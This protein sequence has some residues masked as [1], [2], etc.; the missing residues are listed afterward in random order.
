[1]VKPLFT[2]R[3]AAEK[4]CELDGRPDAD[5]SG[6]YLQVKGLYD[7][8]LLAIM[9]ERAARGASQIDL[10]E[11]CKA[12]LLIALV[13]LGIESADLERHTERLEYGKALQKLLK[14]TA[15]G[16]RWVIRVSRGRDRMNGG[17]MYSSIRLMTR[18]QASRP[19]NGEHS[20]AD[21]THPDSAAE[22]IG[23]T[24]FEYAKIPA[25]ELVAPLLKAANA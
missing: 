2:F 25:S 17:K 14:A 22:V 7:R 1:M 24:L 16:E 13:D 18:F 21:P 23:F 20:D 5:V 6:V 9:E 11:L 10:D 4:F 15:A 3:E 12:R 8:G 19:S